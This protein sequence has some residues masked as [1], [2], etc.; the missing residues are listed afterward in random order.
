MVHLKSDN[1]IIYYQ[2]L[3]LFFG[4]LSDR[5]VNISK[6]KRISINQLY[7]A[8]LNVNTDKYFYYSSENDFFEKVSAD[9]FYDLVNDY[10]VS[11]SDIDYNAMIYIFISSLEIE[12]K[13][14]DKFIPILYKKNAIKRITQLLQCINKTLEFKE[15]KDQ[16]IYLHMIAWCIRNGFDFREIEKLLKE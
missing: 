13:Q 3:Q 1:E 7:H 12:K 5:S 10:V 16:Y 6:Q 4:D 8:F 11:I 9:E 2:K 15:Y 14:K